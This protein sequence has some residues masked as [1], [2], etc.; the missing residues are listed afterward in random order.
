MSILTRG[1]VGEE[2]AARLRMNATIQDIN[3]LLVGEC[4]LARERSN[5]ALTF[6]DSN[7]GQYSMI[8]DLIRVSAGAMSSSSSWPISESFPAYSCSPISRCASRETMLRMWL[9]GS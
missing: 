2:E 9:S 5:S 6:T 8:V 1:T 7:P 4:G 3:S